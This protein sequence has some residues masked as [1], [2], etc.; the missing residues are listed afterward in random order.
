MRASLTEPVPIIL[1][2][3]AGEHVEQDCACPDNNLAPAVLPSLP[4]E[5]AESDCAC[6]DTSL[7][8]TVRL[9]GEAAT[10]WHTAAD[11]HRS[12]LPS[13]HE[14]VFNPLGP[15]SV[16][17][18]NESARAI[19]D[20]FTHPRP[21]NGAASR[22]LAALG[23]LQPQ[24]A[25]PAPIRSQPSSLTAWLH[26]T[27]AC[28]L[29]CTYCYLAKTDKAMDETTGRAAI[30]AIFRSAV[31][32]G[33]RVVKLK[34]AGGEATLNFRL[35]RILHEYAHNLA[36]C[37]G[38]ELREVVLSNG[39]ALTDSMLDFIRDAGM[40][41]MISLDGPGAAHGTQRIFANGRG[42][43]KLVALGVDRALARGVKPYLSIT[44]TKYNADEVARAVAFALDR[45]LLFN[46]NFY[47]DNDYA[48]SHEGLVAEDAQLIAG[49]RAAFKVIEERLPRQSLIAALVD[50]ASFSSPHDH[51]CGAGHN[52][53]VIDQ[54]GRV[55]RCQMEI[56]HTVTDVMASDPLEVVRTSQTGFDNMSVD[57]KVGCQECMWRY[58]CAGGCPLLTYRV[59]G[60]S[61]VKSP[62]CNV[63][64]AL[65]PDVLRLEGLRLMK[66]GAASG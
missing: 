30:D 31:R 42:S 26:V 38:L 22:Q 50:R 24:D 57:E 44:V 41:L 25:T 14:L 49:A 63:Y 19:L 28:N 29:R 13:N 6:S 37:Q 12:P 54:N 21:L 40:R 66:W 51:P 20:A 18:L 10:A 65:Y 9:P 23:L 55:A 58:W 16:V 34:Y 53:L 56:E 35:V 60:R 52:Y 47:R 59:T 43:S 39:V 2:S 61:D 36:A 46:L 45:G 3:Q 48:A 32:H 62:Y 8:S 17:V 15:A 33:F 5:H 4:Q 64:R 27:N 1:W 7:A 11:L